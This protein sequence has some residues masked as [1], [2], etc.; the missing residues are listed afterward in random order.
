MKGIFKTFCLLLVAGGI[1]QQALAQKYLTGELSGSYPAGEYNISGNIYVLPKT[2]L[3]FEAGSILR[4]DNFTGIIV[5]GSL[6]GK[7]TTEQPILLTSTRDIPHGKTAA[8]AFDWN[9]IKATS[10][11]EGITFEYCTIAYSTFGLNIESNHTPVSIKECIFHNNGSASLAREKKM[12]AINENLPFS[13]NWPDGNEP[14]VTPTDTT[15][16]PIPNS[17]GPTKAHPK[18]VLPVRISL[19]AAG[20]VGGALWIVGHVQAEHYNSLLNPPQPGTKIQEVSTSRDNAV[21]LRNVGIGLFAIGV[22]G[23]GVTFFF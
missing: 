2:T 15:P 16:K 17:N 8:E 22:A 10:E 3:T 21:T 14:I 9:G 12:I 19:G 13:Q 11:A 4:F 5:R 23:F 7:G 1:G 6:V 20:V 18:W